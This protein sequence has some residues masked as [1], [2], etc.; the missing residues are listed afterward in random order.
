VRIRWRGDFAMVKRERRDEL[1]VQSGVR[2]TDSRGLKLGS[3]VIKTLFCPDGKND[4]C[5]RKP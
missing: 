4:L 2:R 1:D 3:R 5:S